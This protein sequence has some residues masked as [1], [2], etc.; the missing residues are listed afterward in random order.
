MNP[1][2]Q[3]RLRTANRIRAQYFIS[4]GEADEFRKVA[5]L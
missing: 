1:F 4:H 2:F 5:E 3:E